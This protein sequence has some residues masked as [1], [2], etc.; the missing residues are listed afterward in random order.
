MGLHGER[1]GGAVAVYVHLLLLRKEKS[2]GR[3]SGGNLPIR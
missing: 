1:R 3:S 2:R